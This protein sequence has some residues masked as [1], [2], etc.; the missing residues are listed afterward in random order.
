M[1]QRSQRGEAAPILVL[2]D[3]WSS[4]PQLFYWELL[5]DL[6]GK[7]VQS[8]GGQAYTKIEALLRFFT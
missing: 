5:A 3:E 2:K 8:S 4:Y 6:H 7:V 1:R